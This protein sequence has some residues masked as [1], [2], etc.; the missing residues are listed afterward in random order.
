[1]KRLE[2][3]RHR[4]LWVGALLGL[5]IAAGGPAAPPK[6]PILAGASV[7]DVTPTDLPVIVNGGF[8]S[9]T[10]AKVTSPLSVR[11]LV[12]GAGDDRVAIGVLDTCVIPTDLATRIKRR[13]HELT[14]I[15]E[16]HISISAT[17]T[18]S[19]PSLM[20]ILGTDPDP[21]YP[22]FVFPRILDGLSRAAKNMVSARVGWTSVNAPSH[23]HTRVWIRRPDKML[24]DP[25]GELTVRANMHPGYQNPD[26]VGPAGPSDP[27]MTLLAVQGLDG[28]PIAVLANYAMHYFGDAPISADYYGLFCEKLARQ[29]GDGQCPEGFVAIISQGFSGDQHW[30]DYGSPKPSI[31]IDAYAGE[32]AGIAYGAYRRIEYRDR[33]PIKA[34]AKTLRLRT[35]QPDA[36]RVAWAKAIVAGMG[37][38]AP[39][40]QPEVYAREQLWLL[41]NPERDVPLQAFRV[42]DLGITMTPCEVFAI[43]SLKLKAQSPFS[44]TMNIE[45]ANGEEGYIPPKELHP[46]GGYNTW[47]CRSAGLE[48]DAESK[49]VD[50]LLGLLENVAGTNRRQPH[51]A[52]GPCAEAILAE[53]PLAYWRL[54]EFDGPL[55]NDAAGSSLKASYQ[56]GVALYLDGPASGAFSGAGAI[57]RAPHLAGGSI[58]AET[59]GL[60]KGYSI[61]FWFWNG[62]PADARP[63]TA[64]L[65][66]SDG[67]ESLHIGGNSGNSGRLVFRA[68]DTSLEGQTPLAL[69]QWHHVAIVRQA[70][71]VAIHLDGREHPEISAK[72]PA[73]LSAPGRFYFGGRPGT[74]D[75]L[76]GKIDEIALYD[77][78]LA[79]GAIRT[80][81]ELATRASVAAST[82]QRKGIP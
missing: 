63:I 17:H 32:V 78:P 66:S 33:V 50:G 8:L 10:A 12:L 27:A 42:G 73:P 3:P 47:A 75:T 82:N 35:R 34:A 29:I 14:G 53:K 40:S 44:A 38:R 52:K 80:H 23:T 57:N 49:I 48:V 60:E 21:R 61:E 2:M 77:R 71:Q 15:P 4:R 68:G 58:V 26:T 24:Q 28:R 62:L 79:P 31:T 1:M 76:E 16:G 54:E 25:F 72:T 69:R 41:E 11:W 13:G 30:M 70:A 5:A 9:K 19:A 37:D 51:V 43:S 64:C 20:R 59:T 81:F 18:H 6:G 65:F 67:R 45:L 56:T 46:L 55:A 22:A 39:K 7:T 74:P 36:K